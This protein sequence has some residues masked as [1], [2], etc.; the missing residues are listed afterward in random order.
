[1]NDLHL[2]EGDPP[3]ACEFDAG[4]ATA[5]VAEGIATVSPVGQGRWELRAARK[6]GVAR[7]GDVTVWVKP[8]VPMARLLWMAGWATKAVFG[9]PGPVELEE[10]AELVPALAEAFCLQAE[11]ALREGLLKGYREIESAETVLRGR[12]RTA[13]QLRE[14]YGIP[15][16]LL[17]RYDDHLV[18]IAENQ[19]LKAAAG[20]LLRLPGVGGDVRSR[21]VRL[22]GLL[23]DVS[24]P[25]GAARAL[26]LWHASRL[27]LRY[28]DVLRLAEIIL[29]EGSIEQDPGAVRVDGFL[30]DMYKVFEDFVTAL[31]GSALELRGGIVTAQDPHTLDDDSSIDIKPDMVWRIGGQR[32]AVVDAKYKAE[33]PS[34]FPQ[35]D[36]YQA[37]AYATAYRLDRA[38]L[39]YAAGNEVARSWTVRHAGV[40]LVAHTL[41]L[42]VPVEEVLG[43]VDELAGRIAGEVSDTAGIRGGGGRSLAVARAAVSPGV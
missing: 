21:L 12:L 37:L 9:A 5:L 35:A 34:G 16:P 23:V 3:V 40:Q 30:L 6:V 19:I 10:A 17:I 27:N 24:E 36:L 41:D 33:K 26:P 11:R 8:K 20:R 14:R 13:D 4:I 43:Q 1:M 39:V 7:I 29:A 38:H 31:L 32:V 18:D 2:N 42:G 15:V 28:H 25:V 22:R